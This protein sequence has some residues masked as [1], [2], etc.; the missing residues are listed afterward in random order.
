MS[1]REPA[2]ANRDAWIT[3]A[4]SFSPRL[5]LAAALREVWISLTYVARE[6]RYQ[7][8]AMLRIAGQ[9]RKSVV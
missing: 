3:G 2:A 6:R 1:A 9:D 5:G 4:V 7:R 8:H